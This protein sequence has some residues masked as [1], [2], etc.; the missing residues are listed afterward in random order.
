M[1]LHLL[2]FIFISMAVKNLDEIKKLGIDMKD[3]LNEATND[4]LNILANKIAILL[5]E[6]ASRSDYSTGDLAQSVKPLPVKK[7]GG[8]YVIEIE[9]EEYGT[10]QDA[11]VKGT[12][13]G[14]S[15]GQQLG[16]GKNFSY[17]S[18]GGIRGLKGMPPPSAFER[19]AKSTNTS[20][21]ASSM[22]VFKHG[23][24]PTLW[25]SRTLESREMDVLLDGVVDV[26][27]KEFEG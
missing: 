8:N 11:G 17:E 23:I 7:D 6:N 16:Y 13:S 14:T 24:K 9:W 15:L 2:I 19:F 21:F 27:K 12:E 4:A 25:A 22:S 26:I 3:T 18:K 20:P 1:P 10:Y 5:Q